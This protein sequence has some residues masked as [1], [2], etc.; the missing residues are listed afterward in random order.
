MTIQTIEATTLQKIRQA[1]ATHRCTR[2]GQF[3]RQRYKGQ[4]IYEATFDEE[5]GELTEWRQVWSSYLP[6]SVVPL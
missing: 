3:Y 5:T 6:V 4:P 1:G 2:T